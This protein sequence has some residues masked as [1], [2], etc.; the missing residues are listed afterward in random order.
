MK[1]YLIGGL[2]A[3]HRV[4]KFLKLNCS[5]EL[6]EW[7]EPKKNENLNSY[8]KRLSKQISPNENFGILGV[9]FGG[10][11]AIELSKILNPKKLIIISSVLNHKQLPST[12]KIFVR[13]GIISILPPILLKPPK[14]FFTY[15][16]G[17][18]N[19]RLLNEI[20][21]D[22]KPNFI[23]WSLNEIG[24]WK[25]EASIK[26]VIRI[27]GT[28]DKLIPLKGIAIEIEKG[29]HFMIVDRSDEISNIIN[30]KLEYTE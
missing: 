18:R 13:L 28:N 25:N 15:L 27:H 14:P 16:F 2:G 9:S 20:I 17:A 24:N 7:I 21:I 5:S 3:D 11:V 29:A 23:K 19:K 26:D 22:T 4:F 12:I 6:I 1:I 8:V 30:K 10:I